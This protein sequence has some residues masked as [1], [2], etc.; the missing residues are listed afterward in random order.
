VVN[1]TRNTVN[2]IVPISDENQ[3]KYVI[4]YLEKNGNKWSVN[5]SHFIKEHILG[6]SYGLSF[7]SSKQ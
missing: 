7:S 3:N 4:I 5:H 1:Q 2:F 6:F